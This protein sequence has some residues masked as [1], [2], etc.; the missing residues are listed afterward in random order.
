[1]ARTLIVIVSLFALVSAAASQSLPTLVG[2]WEGPFR[3]KLV[4]GITTGQ[5]VLII[6][7]QDGELFSGRKVI[8]RDDNH[9]GLVTANNERVRNADEKFI[10]VI[11]AD[12]SSFYLAEAGDPGWYSG[13]IMDG[14]TIEL[15]YVESGEVPI[16]HRTT[17]TRQD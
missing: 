1:M 14:D 17:V 9:G 10:G 7:E 16:V 15:T 12:G 2:T 6:D 8:N 4:D 11:S 5:F 13:R 3:A